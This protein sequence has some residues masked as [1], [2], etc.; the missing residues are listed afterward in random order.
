MEFFSPE[1]F[2]PDLFIFEMATA[3]NTENVVE[4]MRD[5]VSKAIQGSNLQIEK[6]NIIPNERI[7]DTTV[8]LHKWLKT[9]DREFEEGNRTDAQ[10]KRILLKYLSDEAFEEY[11][12]IPEDTTQAN[13]YL[14]CVHTLKTAFCVDAP[15]D[16][17][18]VNL[19]SIRPA[20]NESPLTT[21]KRL[22][23]AVK[24][25]NYTNPQEEVMRIA[26]ATITNDKWM[27]KKVSQKWTKANFAEAMAFCRQLEQLKAQKQ[28]M[29]EANE[30]SEATIKSLNSEEPMEKKP[31]RKCLKHHEPGACF[32]YGQIC[33]NCG[34]ENHY[35]RA[36]KNHDPNWHTQ[37]RN[38]TT[39]FLPKS[40]TF[41]YGPNLRSNRGQNF[42]RFQTRPIN[43]R[44][45]YQPMRQGPQRLPN[46]SMPFRQSFLPNSHTFNPGSNLQ[47]NRSAFRPG[48]PQGFRPMS[49]RPFRSR[50]FQRGGPG[51]IRVIEQIPGMEYENYQV[52]DDP[53]YEEHQL[54]EY[55][56]IRSIDS[57][58]EPYDYQ[59]V[60]E[61]YPDQLDQEQ[62]AI[63]NMRSS[64]AIEFHPKSDQTHQHQSSSPHQQQENINEEF[65]QSVKSIRFDE[66]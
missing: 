45:G 6:F 20:P 32:A 34:L 27:S 18:D 62:L 7:F 60:Y 66:L 39:S 14:K 23:K 24:L 25:G 33:N 65:Y 43:Q 48:R 10:K 1:H 5:A 3:L 8:R 38:G 21:L 61:S 54:P 17:V 51:Q 53:N 4:P 26:L 9:L 49:N 29:N 44:Y 13:E 46:P 58:Y 59:E 42:S 56:Y 12:S 47:S 16:A 52:S 63:E 37:L 64:T 11:E 41:N 19:L 28:V 57:S 55:S 50:G 36:C 30:T 22:S 31:C 35:A 2:E 15:E 40:Q